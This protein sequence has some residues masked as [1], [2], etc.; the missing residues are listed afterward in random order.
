MHNIFNV[1]L[2]TLYFSIEL[3]TMWQKKYKYIHTC[4]NNK[5]LR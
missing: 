5:H 3:H 1:Q 2:L 4:N